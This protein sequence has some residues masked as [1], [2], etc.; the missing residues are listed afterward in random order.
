MLFFVF[1]LHYLSIPTRDI[2][3]IPEIYR[4]VSR[5]N[6]LTKSVRGELFHDAKVGVYGGKKSISFGSYESSSI[7]SDFL[8]PSFN[9]G[10]EVSF[11]SVA[12]VGS[13]WFYIGS[14]K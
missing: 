10:K 5:E 6:F 13:V 14:K 3:L 8:V 12:D 1:L 4:K 7:L 2:K 9:S 11:C